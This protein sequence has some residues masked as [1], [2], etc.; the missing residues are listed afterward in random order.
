MTITWSSSTD[1]DSAQSE[2]GVV[3]ENVSNTDHSDGSTVKRGYSVSS[4]LYSSNLVGYWPLHEDGGSTAYDFSGNNNDG[5]ITN[6]NVTVGEGG[7][8][9]TSSYGFTQRG[10]T[11][12]NDNPVDVGDESA[13]DF[14]SG[15]SFSVSVWIKTGSSNSQFIIGKHDTQGGCFDGW[16]ISTGYRGDGG[17][18][19][20]EFQE[21]NCDHKYITTSRTRVDDNN[22][23]HISAVSTGS[24]GYVYIDGVEKVNQSTSGVDF[25]GNGYPFIIGSCY[26]GD[27][28]NEYTFGGNIAEVRVYN[29]NLSSSQVQDLYDVAATDGTLTTDKRSP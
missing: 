26:M 24:T 27:N 6:G 29:T 13:L 20:F 12:S 5:N 1:W 22:W 18:V 9:G 14:G 25:N 23:H 3:H 15:D 17:E 19:T 8:L 7:L 2:S 28:S 16:N 10:L 21:S 4:P 11:T